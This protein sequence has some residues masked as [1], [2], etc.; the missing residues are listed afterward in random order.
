MEKKAKEER[1]MERVYDWER[2][3][4]AW[5]KVKENAGSAGI[6]GMTVKDFED[7]ESELLSLIQGKLEAGNYRFKP[8]KRVLIPKPGSKKRRKLGIPVVMDRI[9]SQSIHQALEEIFDREMTP[10]NYGFRKGKSQ[11]DAVQHVKELAKEGREWCAS[12]D[13]QSFFDEIPHG[14]IFK[15]LRRKIRDERFITLI[16]RALKAGVIEDRELKK[17]RKGCPQ[18]SPV[19]PILSNIVLNELDQELERRGHKYCRWAD[20]FVILTKS[21]RAA[22]R[23]MKSITTFLQEELNLPVNEEK[24]QVSRL[25][26]VTFL[27]FQITGK[28][29]KISSKALERF[30]EK[31]RMLTVRNNPYSM[32]QVI[33]ELNKF[34]RGWVEYFRIQE[35]KESL[36]KLDRF[37]RRRLRAMQ[38]K[39]W[40]KPKK[41]QRVMRQSGRTAKEAKETFVRM[42]SWGSSARTIVK[43]ILC[44]DWFR[45]LGLV[46]L[47]DFRKDS[48]KR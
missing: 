11:Q 28:H 31:V 33:K 8:A 48:L 18:G 25:K 43:K 21:R 32:H 7:R 34:L 45:K 14:L 13:L 3:S 9:V 35:L 16:A 1:V 29:I 26:K 36:V 5:R 20:D 6:D 47:D 41:F 44:L 27:G 30:K 37:I 46:F 42:R 10:S 19:S 4:E 39:K 12:V 15:L 24:S 40:K 17:S 22:E 38:L 23:V 2:L